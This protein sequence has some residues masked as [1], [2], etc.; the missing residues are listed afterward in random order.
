MAAPKKSE[1]EEDYYILDT[2]IWEVGVQKLLSHWTHE[3]NA[4]RD[5]RQLKYL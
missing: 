2:P 5:I 1:D 3:E 4:I